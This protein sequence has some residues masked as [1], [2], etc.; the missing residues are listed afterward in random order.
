MNNDYFVGS[1][2]H[3]FLDL[4]LKSN[5]T[6]QQAHTHTNKHIRSKTNQ[7]HRENNLFAFEHE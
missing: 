2:L 5:A 1:N 6:I 7:T 3:W 4:N